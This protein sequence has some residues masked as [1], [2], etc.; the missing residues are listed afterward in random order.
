M[1]ADGLHSTVRELVFGPERD[2]EHFLDAYV[3]A[4]AAADY[5]DVDDTSY[6]AH[7]IPNRWAAKIQRYDGATVFLL[8]FR[9]S[10]LD[11]EPGH[12]EVKAVLRQVYG[13]MAWE[14][15]WMLSYLDE[16]PVYFD[17]VS[18]IRMPTGPVDAWRSSGTP[19]R[20]YH[21]WRGKGPASR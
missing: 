10:L 17:R 4:Y 6:V 9:A 20:A 14:V 3:A 21:C 15:P 16:G 2:Y 8:I 13:G 18:Q 12:D 19:R 7:S 1:G 5:P 11:R